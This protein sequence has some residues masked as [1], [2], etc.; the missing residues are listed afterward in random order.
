MMN[1]STVQYSKY[2]VDLDL[3][4]VVRRTALETDMASFEITYFLTAIS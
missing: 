2:F 4:T 3:Y 1:L